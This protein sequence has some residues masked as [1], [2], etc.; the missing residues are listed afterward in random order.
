LIVTFD[1]PIQGDA[2]LDVGDVTLSGPEGTSPSV[3]GVSIHGNVL[4]VQ[5]TATSAVS[6]L[7]VGFAGIQAAGSGRPVEESLCFHVLEG[8]CD[9]N[10]IID[11]ADMA[12]IRNKIDLPAN[13]S[14]FQA[15]VHAN[16]VINLY[17]LSVVRD[18][19]GASTGDPGP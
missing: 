11:L 7:T 6:P 10:G 1:L 17:D 4:T 13:M 3:T 14:N 12:V 5:M 8:D 18:N 19:L 9:G 15:D 2:G 16:G